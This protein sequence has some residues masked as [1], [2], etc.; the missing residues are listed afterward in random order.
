MMD[1]VDWDWW[2]VQDADRVC[3]PEDPSDCFDET[4]SIETDEDFD[5]SRGRG[6]YSFM[7]WVDRFDT[8]TEFDDFDNVAGPVRVK[9]LPRAAAVEPVK[10]L[11]PTVSIDPGK[12]ILAPGVVAPSRRSPVFA[13]ASSEPYAVQVIP[14]TAEQ[15]FTV[16]SSV[17]HASLEF[18]PSYPGAVTVE[19]EQVGVWE[20]M[21]VR[22]RKVST[23]EILSEGSGKGRLR[24]EGQ[25]EKVQLVDD[26]LFEV[27]VLPEPGTRGLRGT[28]SVSY[29]DRAVYIRNK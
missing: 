16:S 12:K 11:G 3:L 9:V 25:I 2:V 14:T 17:A 20:K 6:V 4:I 7:L 29:P 13:P 5:G 8:K 21:T 23:G 24:L 18:I 28:I 10:A 1:R 22:L 27:Q 15:S 26:R 19:V